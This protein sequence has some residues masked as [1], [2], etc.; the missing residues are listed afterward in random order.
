MKEKTKMTNNNNAIV[1]QNSDFLFIYEASMC[2]PN[3][4]PDQENKP[5]MDYE[6][7]TNLVSDVRIKRYIRDYLIS[8][9]NKIFVSMENDKKVSAD[10]KLNSIINDYTVD[11]VKFNSLTSNN[12]ILQDSWN[13]LL[14]LAEMKEASYL[15]IKQLAN[16]KG[17]NDA[18]KKKNK[19]LNEKFKDFN[20]LFLDAVIKQELIDIRMFGGAFAVGGFDKTYTGPIQINWGYSL[21]PVELVKSNS[22]VTIMSDD[23]STFGDDHRLY[24]SLIAVHGTVN[25]YFATKTGLTDSDLAAFRNAIIH[26]IPAMPTRSKL[27]QYPV[28]YLELQYK[29]EYDGYLKD[30]RNKLSITTKNEMDESC[31]RDFSDINLDLSDLQTLLNDKNAIISTVHLWERDDFNSNIDIKDEN[32]KSKVQRIPSYVLTPAS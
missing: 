25:K 26:S 16:K 22:I 11:K 30:L 23:S 17:A 8:K 5:R 6:T 2:N 27:G 24:Y 29:S 19:E 1:N 31:I 10:T 12:K 18:E 9:N 13:N 21:N 14:A 15:D 7:K 28:L 3:G 32:N 4:D 20:N